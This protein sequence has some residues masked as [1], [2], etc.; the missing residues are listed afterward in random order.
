MGLI[1]L[2]EKFKNLSLQFPALSLLLCLFTFI[3]QNVFSRE[4]FEFSLG[5][6]VN[7]LSDKAFRK[8]GQ[9]EFE[10]VGN[11]VISHLKNSIYSERAQINFTTG[12]TEVVGN[13]RYIAPDMTLFGTK[14]KY[15]FM[16]RRLELENARILTED[17]SVTGKK[18]IQFDENTIE[19]TEAEYTTCRDCPESWSIFGKKIIVTVGQYVRLHHAFVK[20]KGVVAMYFPYIIFPIKKK[21]ET[22]LLFPLIGFSSKEGFKYQQPFFWAIDD[23]KDLTLTPSTFG[24]RGL[25]GELQYRQ[26]LHEKTWIELNTL[27]LNDEIYAPYKVEKSKTGK[28]EY[29]HFSDFEGHGIYKHFLNGHIYYNQTSDLDT[30][31]DLDFFSKE[32]V[33]GTELGLFSFLDA[34]NSLFSLGIENYFNQNLL[35]D[36]PSIFDHQ[37]VQILPK[38]NLSS[39]PFTIGTDFFPIVKNISLGMNADH[40]IFKQNHAL[41]SGPIRNVQRTNLTPYALFKFPHIGPLFLSHQLKLDYQNYRLPE[42][43]EIKSF[44]KRGMIYETEI[45]FELEK[46]YG[47]AFIDEHTVNEEKEIKN[48]QKSNIIGSLPDLKLSRDTYKVQEF[49]NSYRHSQEVKF[50]H[51]YLSDQ[52]MQGNEIFKNQILENNGQLDS[53]DAI[54]SREYLANQST[55]TD[56]LPLSNTFEIQ[57]NNGLIQKRPKTF[58]PF[59]S[60]RYLKDNF[61]YKNVAYFD[62]SQGIDLTVKTDVWRDRLTRL[63]LNTGHTSDYLDFNL[64]EYY[65]PKFDEHKLVT[66]VTYKHQRGSFTGKFN[67][68]SFNS[69]NTPVTKLVGHELV[70]KLNDLFT[71][72]NSIDYNIETRMMTKSR[73]S[74]LYVPVNNCWKIELGHERDLIEKRFSVLFYIN[75]NNGQFVSINVQ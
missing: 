33:K 32:R 47:L 2:L 45:K 60:G 56:S 26:N 70:L 37:Y 53:I 48:D 4:S 50:K 46:K 34:R 23:Y 6:K 67:Y 18:I 44:S 75:Y 27:Q 22:G 64:N 31:R 49:H 9:N 65:Y 68:N 71:V 29:R 10:A 13:V 12:E 28:K 5:E 55:S 16:T 59:E 63:F 25:G 36:D 35:V 39:V 11:V 21:R 17:Y 30:V 62:I 19:A 51:Y 24:K 61:E 15:N 66:A 14:L 72:K 40:T 52:R 54:R 58:D 1:I 7:I 41:P 73:Y 43:L 3:F 38:I 74:L 20:M 8:T 57:W 42:H 69:N